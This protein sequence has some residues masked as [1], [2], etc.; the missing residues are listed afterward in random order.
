MRPILRLALLPML[1]ALSILPGVSQAPP[2]DAAAKTA[3]EAGNG[4][5]VGAGVSGIV[6]PGSVLTLRVTGDKSHSVHLHAI[7]DP[8]KKFVPLTGVVSDDGLQI[9]LPAVID[10][11]AYY[12]TLVDDDKI[13]IPGSIDIESDRI[14]LTA[15]SPG[16]AYPAGTNR[17][18]FDIIGENFSLNSDNDD[19]TIDG[20]GS[21]VKVRGK[22]GK[23]ED[24]DGRESCL[25]VENERLMHVVGYPRSPIRLSER[26][27]P[28]RQRGPYRSKAACPGP[29]LWNG[30]FLLKCCC[31]R[32]PVLDRFQ[33]SQ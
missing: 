33:G 9:V 2:P 31:D 17:F 28:G 1:A 5:K 22:N 15:V 4:V 19:V 18:N 6:A 24:C 21:I 32:D 29:P 16:T 23:K 8:N 3:P 20:Q 13:I 25:W 7:V 30:C 11:G 12:F 26:R 14:K 27:H 10:P